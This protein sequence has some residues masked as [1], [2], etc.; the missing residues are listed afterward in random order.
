[1]SGSGFNTSFGTGQFANLGASLGPERKQQPEYK[2]IFCAYHST[3][4]LTNFCTD[5][6]SEGMQRNA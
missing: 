1:M 3:E 5:S 6:R 4:F 2:K